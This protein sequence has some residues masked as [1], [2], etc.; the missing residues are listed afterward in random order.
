MN[1]C[2]CSAALAMA[3]EAAK[4]KAEAAAKAAAEAAAAAE[5]KASPQA[6]QNPAVEDAAG[7]SKLRRG[8]GH[9]AFEGRREIVRAPDQGL[10]LT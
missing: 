5:A 2:V 8:T 4:A 1:A 7:L 3:G 10:T 6:T 9:T